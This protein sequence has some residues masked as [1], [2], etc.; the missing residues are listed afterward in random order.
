MNTIQA[1][2]IIIIN[3]APFLAFSSTKETIIKMTKVFYMI[4]KTL[5]EWPTENNRPVPGFSLMDWLA[6]VFTRL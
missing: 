6:I 1:I 3:R 5:S 2:I 4:K